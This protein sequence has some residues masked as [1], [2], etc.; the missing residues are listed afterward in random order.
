MIE[1]NKK[2]ALKAGILVLLVAMLVF[3]VFVAVLGL[4]ETTAEEKARIEDELA[5]LEQQLNVISAGLGQDFGWLL[6]G[7]EQMPDEVV[8]IKLRIEEIKNQLKEIE[9]GE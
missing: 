4:A 9:A 1:I 6:C 8:K 5:Q 7:V 3:G 2:G